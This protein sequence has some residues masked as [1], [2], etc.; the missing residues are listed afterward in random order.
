MQ[1]GK[2]D[3]LRSRRSVRRF[4]PKTVSRETVTSLLDVAM[5]APSAG[6]EQAWQ[7]I[8]LD[9]RTLLE[10]YAALNPNVAFISEAPLAIL[11][12]GDLDSERYA[13]YHVQDCAAATTNLLHAAHAVGLGAVW[14][15]VFPDK[16]EPVRTLL[17]LPEHVIPFSIV[18]LGQPNEEAKPWKSR[19]DTSRIHYNGWN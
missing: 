8:V 15:T 12:C 5:N 18:P 3:Q 13:G 19:L 9:D 16:R 2:L 14:G 6:N 11:V 17:G 10:K 7:F 4:L 1:D